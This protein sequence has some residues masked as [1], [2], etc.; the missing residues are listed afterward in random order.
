MLRQLNSY[1]LDCNYKKTTMSSKAEKT[2]HKLHR[3]DR[4]SIFFR[5][6]NLL[7]IVAWLGSLSLIGSTG[8]VW[9][10]LKPISASQTEAQAL[11]QTSTPVKAQRLD[12]KH[13]E[14]FG[15]YLPTAQKLASVTV[16]ADQLP[17]RE[18]PVAVSPAS[19]SILPTGKI[20][21]PQHADILTADNYTV[22]VNGASS[23]QISVEE[24]MDM[25]VQAPLRA[26]IP[27][28]NAEI[29]TATRSQVQAST[30]ESPAASLT[31]SMP[32]SSLKPQ[33]QAQPASA[34][35]AV[36]RVPSLPTI[37][38][39]AAR[40][41]RSAVP[42]L[43]PTIVAPIKPAAVNP[44]SV[45]PQTVS[46]NVAPSGGPE[47]LD[48]ISVNSATAMAIPVP[49]PRTQ[50]IPVQP[51]AKLP[52]LNQLSAVPTVPPIPTV[53][54][55]SSNQSRP[56][57]LANPGTNEF[58][59]ALIYPL[60][61]PAPTTS[62]FGWRTH[63]ITGSRRFHSGV[64]IGAPMGAPVVAAGSGTIISAGW[65]GGY[66]KAIVIEHSGVRQTLYGHLSE[67]F[68]EPGQTIEQGTVIGRVG[69]TGNST[70]PH[71]HF[72]TRT[73]TADGWVA[74]DPS[75]DINYALDNLRRSMPFAQRDLPPGI[76]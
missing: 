50:T 64:D 10:D 65:V 14:I 47:T 73:A 34:Y 2:S 29:L 5:N 39:I 61:N 43:K 38:S 26:T 21:H 35:R 32:A 1:K 24:L 52:Q 74:I 9:A 71:L 54:L 22:G 36:P 20:S 31:Q 28:Q 30:T 60:T 55:A 57:G 59:S 46:A 13:G 8:V 17:N 44:R 16:S 15:P 25:P 76:N 37:R 62:S 58:S 70:G 69:S 49:S 18:V 12:L 40:D 41:R 33:S 45:A 68:V 66:G 67:I 72:E 56:L 11:L 6:P 19:A 53:R 51:V 23:G 7:K 42:G 75:G 27:H 4:W 3:Q 48:S 63:P